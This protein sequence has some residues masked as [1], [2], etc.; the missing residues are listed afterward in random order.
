MQCTVYR[1]ESAFSR[2]V[3]TRAHP[4]RRLLTRAPQTCPLLALF[5]TNVIDCFFIDTH[6]GKSWNG[7]I[8]IDDADMACEAIRAETPVKH[9]DSESAN[10]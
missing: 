7:L 4:S 5:T 10:I 8:R 1:M 6:L 3:H 9:I 2:D